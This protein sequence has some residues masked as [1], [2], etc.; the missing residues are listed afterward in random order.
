MTKR[1]TSICFIG[2]AV[3]FAVSAQT[4]PRNAQN[5]VGW[6]GVEGKD[7]EL[8]VYLPN[9]YLQHGA[10]HLR[11]GWK[12]NAPKVE[13]M[14]TVAR[15]IN[16]TVLLMTYYNGE[17]EK[18]HQLL[19]GQQG[20]AERTRRETNDFTIY[21]YSKITPKIAQRVQHYMS[22]HRLYVI[23]ALISGTDRRVADAFFNSVRLTKNGIT[24]APN[25]RDAGT[26]VKLPKLFENHESRERDDVIVNASDVDRDVIV[27]HLPIPREDDE[28]NL[29]RGRLQYSME[30]SLVYG[31][32]G[33]VTEVE[34]LSGP[35]THRKRAIDAVKRA[36]FIPA[37][38]DGKLV[39]VRKIFRFSS[40]RA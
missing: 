10:D 28:P 15:Y 20:L 33:K 14:G 17:V 18:I 27:L 2:L 37:Q 13:S 34:V 35:Q 30:V 25:L 21:E 22:G 1:A 32:S 23:E 7:R 3:A 26:P 38:K 9:G 8:V 24:T 36:I 16:G 6:T 12:N 40:V 5:E 39:S 4:T 19:V 31:A 11:L 29:Y